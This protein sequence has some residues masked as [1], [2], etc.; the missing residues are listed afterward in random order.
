MNHELEHL[1]ANELVIRR[2]DHP[3]LAHELDWARVRGDIVSVLPGLYAA[4]RLAGDFRVLA[5]AV[6]KADPDAVIFGHAAATLH[7]WHG[8]AAPTVLSVASRRLHPRRWLRVSQ[9]RIPPELVAR[10]GHVAFT[11]AA[12]TALDLG[13]SSGGGS[14]DESLRSG[15]TLGRLADAAAQVG[16]RRG[17]ATVRRLLRDSRDEPWSYAERQ[18]H[19]H[20]RRAG[21][22]GWKGNRAVRA[23]SGRLVAHLD[24]AFDEAML[25]IEIDGDRW[26]LSPTQVLK[27]RKRDRQLAE[28]GWVVV[29]FRAIEI[30][31]EPEE[32]VA[33]VRR[34][35]AV[36]GARTRRELSRGA[37]RVA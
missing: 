5:L 35:L 6:C 17:D 34:L 20:L 21:I 11:D 24:L 1:L 9:R 33:S 12:L 7:G 8:F 10:D 19:A 2:R 22:L 36:H 15:V 16:P 4:A 31:D 32:F 26:H 13:G 25:D 18:A 14:I 28:L 27:D 23:G 3:G 29:R 30:E 37:K